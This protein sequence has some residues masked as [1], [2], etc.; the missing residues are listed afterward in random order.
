MVASDSGDVRSVFLQRYKSWTTARL[1][2]RSITLR[3]DS[4][5]RPAICQASIQSLMFG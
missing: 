5:H 1:V 3:L 4:H 2:R